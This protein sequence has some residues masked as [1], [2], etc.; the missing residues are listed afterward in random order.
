MPKL[1][2]NVKQI[3]SVNNLRTAETDDQGS[4]DKKQNKQ[5]ENISDSINL[6]TLKE[7]KKCNTGLLQKSYTQHGTAVVIIFTKNI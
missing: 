2:N 7:L 4:R 6:E 5:L 1:R 3:C